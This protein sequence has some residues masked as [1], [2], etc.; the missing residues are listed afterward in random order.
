VNHD[1][2]W[3]FLQVAFAHLLAVASPG[4]DLAIVLRQSLRYGRRTAFWTSL[5]VG[6]GIS[7]HIAY[8]LL[9]IGL[10]VRGSATAFAVLKYAGAAYLC[11]VGVQ[12]LR[13]RPRSDE[14]F[15]AAAA[16]EGPTPR[17]AWVTGFL[18]NALNPKVTF[19]FV[20]LFVAVISPATSKWIQAVYGLWMVLATAGWFCLVATVLTRPTVRARLLRHG[21]WIDRGIGAIFIVF[22]VSLAGASLR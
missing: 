20:A 19:F 4:P 5:G 13:A 1:Y 22:A 18:T 15:S 9:G 21:H 14:D 16:A 7:L 3:E 11:W 6:A 8:S 10:L 12:G 17:A 2:R